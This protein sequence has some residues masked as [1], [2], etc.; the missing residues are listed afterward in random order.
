MNL[1]SH[2]VLRNIL[3]RIGVAKYFSII[4]DEVTDQTR[5]HQLG[6]S[7]RWVDDHFLVHEDFLELYLL[8]KGDADT[9]TRVIEDMLIRYQLPLSNCRGQ[10]YDGASV[11]AG[12]ITGVSRHIAD[13]ESRAVFIYSLA[14]S[15]NLA[16]QESSRRCP[17]Y[18]DMINYV[19]DV[20]NLIRA[21]P[22]RSALLEEL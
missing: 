1:L 11:M 18:R 10:C 7:I 8:P 15:L 4:G 16:L 22:K 13:V 20:I 3:N 19:K 17:V 5:Q 21:S 6:I 9:I 12:H 2:H 14:H